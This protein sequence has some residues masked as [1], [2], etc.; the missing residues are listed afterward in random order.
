MFLL[1]IL[2]LHVS[3]LKNY[4]GK[5]PLCA[6]LAGAYKYLNFFKLLFYL[7]S[8]KDSPTCLR[9]YSRSRYVG[10]VSPGTGTPQEMVVIPLL[11]YRKVNH[12]I[13]CTC[14]YCH[15]SNSSESS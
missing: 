6:N 7:T 14:G 11:G 3:L 1:L 13:N 10:P 2:L 12:F 8:K 5:K 9:L 4:G 15:C